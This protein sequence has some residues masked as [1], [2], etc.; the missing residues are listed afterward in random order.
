MR[1]FG[2]VPLRPIKAVRPRGSLSYR[3]FH[4]AGTFSLLPLL[5]LLLA[6][7]YPFLMLLEGCSAQMACEGEGACHFSEAG[8]RPLLLS[9][10]M[11]WSHILTLQK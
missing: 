7:L 4:M 6:V 5:A 3:A 11:I 8:T 10:L 9:L 1:T 2:K